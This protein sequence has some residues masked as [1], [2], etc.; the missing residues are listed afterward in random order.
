MLKV[1]IIICTCNRPNRVNSLVSDLSIY[2]KEYNSIIIVDSSDE[3]NSAKYIGSQLIYLH[4]LH[5]NQ[6]FQRY[7]G[8]QNSIADILIFLD[9]DME[10]INS[11]FLKIIKNAFFDECVAG[12]AINFKDKHDDSSLALIPKSV[13]FRRKNRLNK[14]ISWLSG[15][16]Q[17]PVG[18]LGLCGIRGIQPFEGG[19]TECVSGGAFAAR[20]LFVFQNFNFQLFDLYEEQLGKGED[21]VIGYSLSKFGK[22]LFIPDLLF[23]HNDQKDSNYS[24]NHFAFAKRVIFSRLFLSLEKKRLDGGSFIL[25]YTH[26]YWFVL[27]RILGLCLNLCIKKNEVNS[28]ILRG[29][30]KGWKLAFKFKY[31]MIPSVKY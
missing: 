30:I 20:R 8:A 4:S 29:S 28:A 26:Y 6:P 14:Y 1:D 24:T 17:L 2:S 18:K 19:N 23:L 9:D 31:K 5:K 13:L 7:L 21:V 22:I 11:D 3:M 16:P 15:Y 27:W 12:I 10:L 25:A